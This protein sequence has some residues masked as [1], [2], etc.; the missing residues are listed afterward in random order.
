MPK[1]FAAALSDLYVLCV[2]RNGN[3]RGQTPWRN[4]AAGGAK[5]AAWCEQFGGKRTGP[6]FG[7]WDKRAREETRTTA[8][9]PAVNLAARPAA[10]T[11]Q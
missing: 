6:G 3:G 5:P 8:I 2:S 10:A 9:P 11:T 4:P 7:V 1:N